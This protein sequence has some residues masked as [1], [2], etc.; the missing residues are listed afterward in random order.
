M[1]NQS[2]PDTS[3]AANPATLLTAKTHSSTIRKSSI[4]HSCLA[5]RGQAGSRVFPYTK[6]VDKKFDVTLLIP[7]GE[8]RTIQVCPYEHIRDVAADVCVNI[9]SLCHK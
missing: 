7:K 2:R 3:V 4:T 1:A 9:P 8:E 6:K 5:H